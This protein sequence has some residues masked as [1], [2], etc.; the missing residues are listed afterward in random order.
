MSLDRSLHQT[1]AVCPATFMP[2]QRKPAWPCFF[3]TR[4]IL[5]PPDIA[6]LL[7]RTPTAFASCKRS[8]VNDLQVILFPGTCGCAAGCYPV[9]GSWAGYENPSGEDAT[10]LPRRCNLGFNNQSIRQRRT[11]HFTAKNKNKLSSTST[12]QHSIISNF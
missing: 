9:N 7:Q 6:G 10:R 3:S 4:T 11:Q 8:R 5:C 1:Y 12:K 2:H